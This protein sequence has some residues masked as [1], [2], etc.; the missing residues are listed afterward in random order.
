MSL[1]VPP[2]RF[3]P[4]VPEV[5]DRH[6]NDP[7][8]LRADLRVL[9]HINR[10]LGGYHI[11]LRYLAELLDKAPTERITILDLATGAADVPRAVAQWA[12]QRGLH[13]EI[14]AVDANPEILQIARERSASWPEIRFEQRDLLALPYSP[15]SFDVVLCS[16]T[17]HHFSE[18]NAVAVLQRIHDIARVGYIVNDLRRSCI[19]IGLSKLM[20]ATIITNPIAKFDAPASCERAFRVPELRAMA[21]K[22]GLANAVIRRQRFFRMSIV[23]RK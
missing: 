17:L 3:D 22:A 13:A 16:L 23:G 6:G 20:A 14:T 11:P 9:E 2:R 7:A 8:L 18:P 19:A 4:A 12:R 21:R 5:M 15:A 1:F 10:R